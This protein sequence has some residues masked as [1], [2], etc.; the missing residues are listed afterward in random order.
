MSAIARSRDNEQWWRVMKPHVAT[1]ETCPSST[2][3]LSGRTHSRASGGSFQE[4]LLATLRKPIKQIFPR[5]AHVA[6]EGCV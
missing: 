2:D 6:V 4:S 1:P 3:T 5:F